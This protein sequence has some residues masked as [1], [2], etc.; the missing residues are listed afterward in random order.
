M[1]NN[2]LARMRSGENLTLLQQIILTLQL[3]APTILAHLSTVIMQYIDA[4]MVGQLGANDSASIG[5]VSSTIWLFSDLATAL[6]IGFSVLTAQAIGAGDEK[7]AR[8]LCKQAFIVAGGFALIL[9]AVGAAISGALPQ[10]LGGA[11]EIQTNASRYFLVFA[12]SIPFVQI[13]N[14]AVM[15]L[16]A[17]G[18]MKVPSICM[19]IMCLLDVCFN[20]LFIF[21][22]REVLGIKIPGLGLGVAGAALG[23]LTAQAVVGAFLVYY[24]I[25]RVPEMKF[26]RNEKFAFSATQLKSSIKIS[27]PVAAERVVSCGAQ[28]M[29]T[30]I[31]APLGAVSIAAHSFSVTAEGLCYLPGYGIMN[32]SSAMIG[33]SVGAGRKKLAFRLGW[34]SVILGMALMTVTGALLYIFAP[35]VLGLMTPDRDV[36][37][38]GVAVLRI[39]LFSEPF[40]AASIVGFGV[41]QG[42]GQTLIPTI[43]NL[44]S[45]WGVRI[46]L[47]AILTGSLGLR[48]TWIAMCIELTVRGILF[49]GYLG[50][51]NKKESKG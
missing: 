21:P 23:T 41:F 35:E 34:I 39:E 3:S 31:V 9:C 40:F 48:G 19:I 27:L 44:V 30:R 2:L 38:L 45:M 50:I 32:A 4:S 15:E 36:V 43:M 26:R 20:A 14:L 42:M 25:R 33:Q 7:K 49:L 46:P 28:I 6:N 22:T 11:E 29:L 17:T 37:E 1:N 51:K 13:N 10:L 5:L 47:V 12:F 24:L 18:N 8:Q 16:E